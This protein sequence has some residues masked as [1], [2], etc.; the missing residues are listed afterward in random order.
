MITAINHLDDPVNNITVVVTC[1]VKHRVSN[2]RL[3]S[4]Q[5]LPSD[6]GVKATLLRSCDRLSI[7]SKLSTFQLYEIYLRQVLH[8]N[9]KTR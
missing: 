4:T 8:F 5:S 9:S 3:L 2:G 7:A 6:R 1:Q